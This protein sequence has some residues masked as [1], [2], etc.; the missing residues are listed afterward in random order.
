MAVHESYIFPADTNNSQIQFGGR[1]LEILDANAGLAAVKFLPSHLSFVT[2]GYDHTQF[3]S[4]IGPSDVS[5]CLSYVTGADQKAVEVFTKFEA[6]DQQTKKTRLA[7]MS[8]CT[9]VV[10]NPLEEIH[11]PKLMPETDEEIYL[12]SHYQQ[13]LKQRQKTLR[14]NRELITHLNN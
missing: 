5:K 6:Y 11:F 3:L 1:T 8:F 4:P 7:F 13:R 14:E 12:V 9:L 2:A 10:T